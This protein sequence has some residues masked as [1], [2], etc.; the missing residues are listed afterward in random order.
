M[1]P[2]KIKNRSKFDQIG[3]SIVT[4]LLKY[5]DE[6]TTKQ[7]YTVEKYTQINGH[8]KLIAQHIL[9][10]AN[11]SMMFSTINDKTIIAGLVSLPPSH[12]SKYAR[13]LK[14]KNLHGAY[15]DFNKVTHDIFVDIVYTKRLNKQDLIDAIGLNS[16]P[17]CN[18]SYIYSVTSGKVN[19]QL[20]HFYPKSIYPILAV[21]LYNLIPACAIC[22]SAGAKGS[23][24]PLDA[25]YQL[26]SPHLVKHDDFHFNY[27]LSSPKIITGNINNS[28]VSVFFDK[29]ANSPNDKV[30]HLSSFYQQHADHVVDLLYKRNYVYT[31]SYL[32]ALRK[33]TG[34]K[35]SQSD[36]DRFIVGAYVSPDDYHKRPLSK[37]YAEIATEIGLIK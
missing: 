13:L 33:I 3:D 1:I 26:I 2:I 23:K 35:I 16:C 6:I 19:P 5:I 7:Y 17:Y 28:D 24:D 12:F 21:S 32:A 22:N 11:I 15:D 9:V 36:L 37:L 18:R 20:D 10:D 27:Q 29:G 30:F 14:I 34:Q 31:D 4:S 25:R 8:R